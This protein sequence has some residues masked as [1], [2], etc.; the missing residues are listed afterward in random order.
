M[1]PLALRR[2]RVASVELDGPTIELTVAL[3][4]GLRPAIAHRQLTGPVE[5]GDDVVVNVAGLDLALSSG[6]FDVV[7]VNLTRGLSQ[8]AAPG[9]AVKLNYTSLQHAV[10]PVESDAAPAE[11]SESLPAVPLERPVAVIALHGQLE[12]VAWA[13]AQT[14][15]GARV[16]YVQSAGG[17][18]PGALSGAVRELRRRELLAGHLTA[19]PCFGG[20]DGEAV[21]VAGAI[22]AGL[23]A[24]GWH[25]AIVGPGPGLA[26]SG[27]A[28]GHGGLAALDSAHAALALGA[29]TLLVPRMSSGD[30]RARHRPLSH[31]SA[32][33]LE[34]LLRT[35]DVALPAELPERPAALAHHR[36]REVETDLDGYRGAGLGGLT[37]GRS[38]DED[39]LF[40]RAALAGGRVLGE[41]IEGVRAHRR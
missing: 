4:E 21:S 3:A 26:G 33:V 14:A 25:A 12:P 9:Q 2:G 28:F 38:I 39:E 6:G 17:A 34:L 30:P 35:V 37:M 36:H 1:T 27:S 20:A 7:H 31:H 8:P 5:A 11:R 29:R 18:L 16:G 13:A 23:T 22:H 41:E 19:G 24:L 15:P 10:V 40:F 32:T